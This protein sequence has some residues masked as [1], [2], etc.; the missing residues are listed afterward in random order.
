MRQLA[1]ELKLADFALFDT[2]H[3]GENAAVV[4]ALQAAIMEPGPAVHWVWGAAGSG[5]SHLLQAAVAAAEGRCAWL[6]LADCAES[7]PEMLEGM[8]TLDL[9]CVDDIDAVAGD[10]AWERQ[11]FGVFED[12]KAGQGR[13]IVSASSAPAEAGFGLRDLA[14]RL[15]SGPVWRLQTLDDEQLLTAL[16]LRAGWRGLELSK[17]A[18][19]FLLRRVTR[20][21][22]ALF[23]LLD[24]ADQAAL[25]A[26]RRL[27]VPFLKKVLD[28]ID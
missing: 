19:R 10:A 12:L 25:E 24:V 20:S 18:G 4:A 6:P 17:E 15:A 2:Y 13:L 22:A 11:L 27:T 21:T 8:G 28:S 14:S 5:R 9:L 23:S 16:Q 26:Q 7:P 1:L 3:A